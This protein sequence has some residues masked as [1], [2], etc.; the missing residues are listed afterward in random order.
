MNSPEQ[1]FWA[2]A[3]LKV[4]VKGWQHVVKVDQFSRSGCALSW[5]RSPCTVGGNV[6]ILV[7]TVFH[8]W[9]SRLDSWFFDT[10]QHYF[11]KS[12]AMQHLV[13]QISMLASR[14]RVYFRGF[15]ES[16]VDRNSFVEY[17]PFTPTVGPFICF[18][19]PFISILP[20]EI[21]SGQN[22]QVKS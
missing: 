12:G 3:S 14:H 13:T 15:V 18:E 19:G 16:F 10:V 4:E 20:F 17:A 5:D 9:G 2:G 7:P 21:T 1:L 6:T 11:I 22:L 8:L